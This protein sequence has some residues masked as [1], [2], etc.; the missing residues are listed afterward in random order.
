MNELIELNCDKIVTSLN[1]EHSLNAALPISVT[2]EGIFI[3]TI[4]VHKQKA[5]SPIFVTDEGI[6]ISIKDE[7]PLNANDSIKTTDDGIMNCKSDLH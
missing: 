5:D 1:D 4:D 6:E 3:L 2:D 7:H